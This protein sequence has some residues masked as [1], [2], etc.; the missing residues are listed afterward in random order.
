MKNIAYIVAL[1]MSVSMGCESWIDEEINVDPNN[2][3][4][5]SS[6]NILAA[7]EV[8]WGYLR[9]SDLG[10]FNSI[11][12]QHHAGVERQHAG[13]EVYNVKEDDVN[14]SWNSTYSDVLQELDIIIGKAEGE[15]PSPHFAGVAKVLTADALMLT[16]DMYGDVPFS[17]AFDEEDLTPAYDTQTSVYESIQ[18][19][20]DAAIADL[21]AGTSTFSPGANDDLIYGGDLANWQLYA[22]TLK[23]KAY[24][25]LGKVDAQNYQRA[26][27]QIDAGVFAS[28]EDD[29]EIQFITAA[30]GSSPWFQFMDQRGDIRMG[31]F[32]INLMEANVDPRLPVF[33]DSSGA[34]AFKGAVAGIPDGSAN[35]PGF[36]AEADAIVPLATYAEIKFVEAEAAFQTDDTDRAAAAHNAGVIASLE[37]FGVYDPASPFVAA[38]A[39]FTGAAITLEEIMTQKYV[40]MYTNPESYTDW[41]R[42]GIPNLAP[43]AGQS[44][45]IL[46][47]PTPQSERL[48]NSENAPA[49]K[50]VFTPLPWDM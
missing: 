5:V 49:N 44:Q 42:T 2:P 39:Q 20:L 45:I 48:Y 10:R 11:F 12:T 15:S 21:S 31:A 3:I 25:H 24:L 4:E 18:S 41:R 46:Q 38:H 23:A 7:P 9:G 1:L 16:T 34:N 6:S 35:V 27:D 14:N 19:L 13:F 40:A 8:G 37:K 29:A 33:A 28:N 17:Q 26:L 30:T 32:F 36:Y 47:W 43:A 50:N 22:R